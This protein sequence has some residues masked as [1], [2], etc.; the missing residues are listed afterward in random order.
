L[1]VSVLPSDDPSVPSPSDDPSVPSPLDDPIV[2]ST[3][4]TDDE[5]YRVITTTPV[6]DFPIIGKHHV[7]FHSSATKNRFFFTGESFIE[8]NG[9][10]EGEKWR[11]MLLAC[12]S[13]EQAKRAAFWYIGKV[14]PDLNYGITI[15]PDTV[16]IEDLVRDISEYVKK[17]NVPQEG[18]NT[19][20]GFYEGCEVYLVQGDP[21]IPY[22]VPTVSETPRILISQSVY[23]TYTKITIRFVKDCGTDVVVHYGT[24]PQLTIKKL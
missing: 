24:T 23:D 12:S 8:S 22:L 6:N 3:C 14:L 19:N 20:D 15:S 13:L 4:V 11:E 16:T 9:R 5:L 1:V 18:G 2:P 7:A 17:D 10:V 21:I